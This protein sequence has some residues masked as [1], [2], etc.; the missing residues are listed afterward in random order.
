MA[1]VA[2]DDI[3]VVLCCDCPCDTCWRDAPHLL[4]ALAEAFG[5]LDSANEMGHLFFL[6]AS[7]TVGF[8]VGRRKLDDKK[9]TG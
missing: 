2:T 5:W 6:A 3:V 9:L 4:A 8:L 7:A 1:S